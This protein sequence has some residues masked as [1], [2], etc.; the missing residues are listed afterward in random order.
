MSGNDCPEPAVAREG[1]REVAVG[2]AKFVVGAVT[3]KLSDLETAEPFDTVMGTTIGKVPW[4]AVSVYGM[5]ALS[6]V[7]L[8]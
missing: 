7:A 8:T 6:C 3:E 4:V 1:E 2:A 5:I